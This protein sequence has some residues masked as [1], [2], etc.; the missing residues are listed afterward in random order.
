ML[1]FLPKIYGTLYSVS[2]KKI[3]WGGGGGDI[4]NLASHSMLE[5]TTFDFQRL[6][7]IH[8][9]MNLFITDDTHGM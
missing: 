9:R 8:P 2:F 3:F 5:T 1:A 7:K 4:S 6:V